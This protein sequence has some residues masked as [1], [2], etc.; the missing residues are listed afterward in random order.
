MPAKKDRRSILKD[1]KFK[2]ADLPLNHSTNELCPFCAGGPNNDANTFGVT[3]IP[4]GLLYNCLRV[5]CG[6]SGIVF[7][8]APDYR[9]ANVKEKEKEF[10]PYDLPVYPL[11]ATELHAL[12]SKYGISKEILNQANIRMDPQT[13][14]YHLR[15]TNSLGYPAG[16]YI[17]GV[18]NNRKI[19]R[20]TNQVD[21]E[22]G[23]Y[24]PM[25]G[26]CRSYHDLPMV[27]VVE[28]PF[29]ALK[30]C[31]LGYHCVALLGTNISDRGARLLA[32]NNHVVVMLDAD[33]WEKTNAKQTANFKVIS[34]LKPFCKK[35]WSIPIKR[36]PKD[37]EI[38]T[39]KNLLATTQELSRE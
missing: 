34:R 32:T 7:N 11:T 26:K 10:I 39:L 29:S 25:V 13:P 16:Y 19:A 3:Q 9:Q 17:K 28:D 37:M 33:T 30:I 18:E 27:V 24:F 1:L 22:I 15:L 38:T 14:A 8:D 36:D 23:I 12:Y 31:E 21:E 35:L 20:W 4:D 6:E 5:T 2:H